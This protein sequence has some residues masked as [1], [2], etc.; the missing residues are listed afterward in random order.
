MRYTYHHSKFSKKNLKYSK[1]DIESW[2]VMYT[3]GI[4]STEIASKFGTSS[5]YVIHM[6][7]KMGVPIRTKSETKLAEKNP[8]WV[9]DSVKYFPLHKWVKSRLPKPALCNMCKKVP[10]LDLA[11]KGIYNRDL[12]NWEWLCRRCHMLSDGR[13]NNLKQYGQKK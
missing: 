7:R 12:C 13:M 10:P 2:A 6:L 8:M 5:N 4:N 1:A 11:N 3:S 9:G